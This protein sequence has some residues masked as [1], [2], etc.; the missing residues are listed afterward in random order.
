M[1]CGRRASMTG[2][3]ESRAQ[4][5]ALHWQ[6]TCE[7]ES[8]SQPSTWAGEMERA[9]LR[10]DVVY[11]VARGRRLRAFSVDRCETWGGC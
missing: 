3:H 4:S 10:D 11:V 5:S 9:H 8:R 2:W 7:R 1:S 6:S